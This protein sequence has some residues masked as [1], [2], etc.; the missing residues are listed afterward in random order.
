MKFSKIREY[1]STRIYNKTKPALSLLGTG[2][3]VKKFGDFYVQNAPELGIVGAGLLHSYV[4]QNTFT[5]EELVAYKKGLHDFG[6]LFKQAH[7]ERTAAAEVF[8][9]RAGHPHR[10]TKRR[11][12]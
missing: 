7:S 3:N 1:L 2:V 6:G 9:R 4:S 8:S 12:S 5:P 10:Q 11:K